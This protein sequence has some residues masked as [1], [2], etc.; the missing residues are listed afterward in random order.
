[1]ASD[2]GG[3][4]VSNIAVQT[5][6]RAAAP[7][8]ARLARNPRRPTGAPGGRSELVP[9][10]PGGRT[11]RLRRLLRTRHSPVVV[12]S[13]NQGEGGRGCFTNTDTHRLVRALA[14]LW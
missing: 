10:R 8:P 5:A 11:H 9:T 1:M 7:T 12:P 13:L 3:G 14:A 2:G 4:R 6:L